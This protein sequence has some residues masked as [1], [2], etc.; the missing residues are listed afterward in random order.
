MS[1]FIRINRSN[2]VNRAPTRPQRAS[3]RRLAGSCLV[4][5]ALLAL[6]GAPIAQAAI[7]TY[8]IDPATGHVGGSSDQLVGTCC[9]LAAVWWRC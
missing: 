8:T 5:L 3:P 4:L 6:L 9:L 7:Q 1:D 2:R